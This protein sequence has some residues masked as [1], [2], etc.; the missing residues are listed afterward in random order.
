MQIKPGVIHV[1]WT[2]RRRRGEREHFHHFHLESVR[3]SGNAAAAFI[4]IRGEATLPSRRQRH[5]GNST[6]EIRDNSASNPSGFPLSKCHRRQ[7]DQGEGVGG[8]VEGGMEGGKGRNVS[9]MAG[10]PAIICRV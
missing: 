5:T 7:V 3:G 4:S 9:I 8:G 2:G 10:V 6:K 1:K